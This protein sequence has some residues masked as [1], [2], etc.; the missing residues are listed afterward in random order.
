MQLR[1]ADI[2]IEQ[3]NFNAD[4]RYFHRATY[5][6]IS[7]YWGNLETIV[8]DIAKARFNLYENIF[9]KSYLPKPDPEALLEVDA[10]RERMAEGTYFYHNQIDDRVDVAIIHRRFNFT[11]WYQADKY[12]KKR[13]IV[14]EIHAA[15]LVLAERFG[16]DKGNVNNAYNE[17]VKANFENHWISKKLGT[18]T[19]PDRKRKGSIRF[20]Y[21][22]DQ[23]R[24]FTHITDRD[25]N[26][27]ESNLIHTIDFTKPN[28]Y[29]PDEI[30]KYTGGKTHW[31]NGALLLKAK[32]DN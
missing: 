4:K 18:K 19:S 20:E 3:I 29:P 11:Q 24:V 6:M 13:M 9:D 16:W 31:E 30:A 25:G 15:M 21:D 14:E 32:D 27:L 12:N 28:M 23:F 17:C 22:I 5:S 10:V 2:G 7:L 1:Y 26:L 8:S